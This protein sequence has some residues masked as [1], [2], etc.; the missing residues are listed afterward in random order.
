MKSPLTYLA[1]QRTRREQRRRDILRDRGL[2]ARDE[3]DARRCERAYQAEVVLPGRIKT[4]LTGRRKETGGTG[5]QEFD[6]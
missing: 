1:A 6:A 5:F 4:A 3:M 2:R